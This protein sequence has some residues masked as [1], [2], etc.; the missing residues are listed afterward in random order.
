MSLTSKQIIALKNIPNCGIK[1]VRGICEFAKDSF[2]ENPKELAEIVNQCRMNKIASR[3]KE[4]ISIDFIEE[5][6]NEAEYILEKSLE[7][8]IRVVNYQ[9]LSFPQK[10][11]KTIDENGNLDVPI[12]LYYKGDLNIASLPGIAIIGTREP[13]ID[14]VKAGTYLGKLFADRG[15]NIVSGLAIGCDTAGHKGALL[16]PNGKTTSFLAHGLDTIYPPENTELA[17]EIVSRGGLL[18]SEY[19][20]GTRVNRYNLV[21]RDRLQAALADATIVIQTGIKGGT[22]HAANTTLMAKKSLFCVKYLNL[23]SSNNIA[24]NDYLVKKGGQYLT[25]KDPVETVEQAIRQN[26][27]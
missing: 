20:I 19:P 13:T 11:L 4:N 15:Y 25:S 23:Q 8:G 6:L 10:L 7:L 22:M 24:G 17:D 5:K 14:G 16:S 18:F 9:E 1:T 27:K 21:A 12:L 2:P 3:L 26:V